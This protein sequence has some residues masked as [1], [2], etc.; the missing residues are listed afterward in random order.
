MSLN[1]KF[2][3]KATV[4]I[5]AGTIGSVLL[6]ISSI[7]MTRYVAKETYGTY[8]QAMLI[9]NTINMLAY[10]G[11][12]QS[13]YFYFQ[14]A[15]NKVAFVCRNV[16]SAFAIGL[17]ACTLLLLCKTTISGA[18][19]NSE[20]AGYVPYLAL[21]I[22][23]QSPMSFREPLFYSSGAFVSNS[24]I[25]VCCAI[26]DYLPLY[27]AVISGCSLRAI[28]LVAIASKMINLLVFAVLLKKFCL[29]NLASIPLSGNEK[30][31]RLV[32]QLR[33]AMPIGAAGYVGVIGNQV[34]KYIISSGFSPAEFAVYSRGAMEVPF[35]STI[36]YMLNNMTLPQY[37]AAYKR[38]D[39]KELLALM[40]ANIDKVAKINI[41]VF[42]F[43]FVEAQLLMEILYTAKYAD[44]TPIFRINIL[45]LLFGVTVYNMIPTVT[46]NTKTFFKATVLSIVAKVGFCLLLL[47]VMGPTGVALGVLAGSL[48]YMLYLLYCSVRILEV[49]WTEIMPWR[50][51][52]K[53]CM[54]AFAAGGGIKLYHILLA[55]MGISD[56]IVVLGISFCFYCYI[57]LSGLNL[58]GLI[59]IEDREFLTRW[60]RVNPFLFMPQFKGARFDK[61][62][63]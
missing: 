10:V 31:V 56:N 48:L 30:K 27:G 17:A 19:G 62:A 15:E 26:V 29:N 46:G 45:S 16:L 35:I 21:I 11:L 9:I 7:I 3:D 33:Y 14:S 6:M 1:L 52:W 36:T 12:P 4:N 54:V 44:A 49:G 38:R 51:V 23:L 20:L 61:Q 42:A 22:L 2:A 25:T 18:L 40:H 28:F 8:L 13:I 47:R 58:S 34:D 53:I 63:E 60:L 50:N 55:R 37:V 32:D 59:R 5:L 43:L 39:I 41:A 57:Y 24:M